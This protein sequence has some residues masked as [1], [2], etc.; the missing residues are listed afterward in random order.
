MNPVFKYSDNRLQLLEGKELMKY[1][2]SDDS[3]V[4]LLT[5]NDDEVYIIDD[6][7]LIE[8]FEAIGGIYPED[9]ATRLMLKTVNPLKYGN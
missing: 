7:E 3:K 2:A 8:K 9:I 4:F 6:P 5:G 1:L